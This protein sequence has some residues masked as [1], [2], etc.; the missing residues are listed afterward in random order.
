MVQGTQRFHQILLILLYGLEK[1]FKKKL[2][3]LIVI[4]IVYKI[5]EV[6]CFIQT[7]L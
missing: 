7:K 5:I 3:I 4:L 2:F 1:K 6:V